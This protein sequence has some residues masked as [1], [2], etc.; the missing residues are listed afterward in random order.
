ME[1]RRKKIDTLFQNDR[2]LNSPYY[3]GDIDRRISNRPR[4]VE[5]KVEHV[6]TFKAKKKQK[7]VPFFILVILFIASAALTIVLL[8]FYVVPS[9]KQQFGIKDKENVVLEEM[10]D[11]ET[12]NIVTDNI[13][14]IVTPETTAFNKP[15]EAYIGDRI[16][17]TRIKSL[18]NAILNHDLMEEEAYINLIFNGDEIHEFIPAKERVKVNSYYEVIPFY[19]MSGYIEEIQVTEIKEDQE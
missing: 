2:G 19:D 6:D 13:Y 11:P 8:N 18:I 16:E 1:D 7:F 5:G 3:K 10:L 9:L 14:K 17:G 15:Y 12:E 4:T